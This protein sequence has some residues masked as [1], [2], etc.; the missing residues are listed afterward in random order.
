MRKKIW[1]CLIGLLLLGFITYSQWHVTYFY[2][3]V[4]AVYFLNEDTGYT[5][6]V[7]YNLSP[8]NNLRGQVW[9]TTDGG[10]S[11]DTCLKNTPYHNW[12]L[13]FVNDQ[14]GY[15]LG[16]NDSSGL[17]KTSNMGDSWDSIYVTTN[18]LFDI[19]FINK[20]T[21][22]VVGNGN[23][24]IYQT[25]DGGYTW[26]GGFKSSTDDYLLKICFSTADTGFALGYNQNSAGSIY[27]TTDKGFTWVDLGQFPYEF[28]DMHFFNGNEGI[29]VGYNKLDGSSVA[30]YTSNA[31]S[32]FTVQ[33]SL[34]LIYGFDFSS[35]NS[36]KGIVY[37]AT[38]AYGVLRAIHDGS[39]SKH[40]QWTKEATPESFREI[41]IQGNT[42]F[43]IGGT[44]SFYSQTN[45]ITDSVW[46]GD[47]N[48]DN[49]AN[50][51][52]ILSIGIAY[53][54]Q[55]I[56]RTGA[57][58][59]WVG[60]ACNDWNNSF[61]NNVNYKHAD[62]DGNGLIDSLDVSI[63]SSNYGLTH[64]K[65]FMLTSGSAADPDLYI[66]SSVDTTG[67]SMVFTAKIKLGTNLL[68]AA[69]VYGFAL[70]VNYNPNLIDSGSMSVSFQ[71]SWIASSPNFIS[72]V[73]DVY[74]SGQ[75][76][77]GFSRIDQVSV[78]GYGEVAELSCIITDNIDGKDYIYKTLALDFN[79]AKIIDN[80]ETDIA[81]NMFGDSVIIQQEQLS[82]EDISNESRISIYPSPFSNSFTIF[83][84]DNET[85]YDDII[86]FNTMGQEFNYKLTKVSG[87]TFLCN[88]NI[89]TGLYFLK[90]KTKDGIIIKKI[91]KL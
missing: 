72:L 22:Y 54:N 25:K 69:N 42:A 64:Y 39:A 29:V 91:K 44:G 23:A 14:I 56:V 10:I 12:S 75:I 18:K 67:A 47:A 38:G 13:H 9:R 83:L 80:L 85:I 40:L 71:N 28:K 53:G 5:A 74:G 52:D 68:P 51:N 3:Y 8:L 87:N 1:K 55:G 61:S 76:N 17:Y 41:D 36:G 63:V 43:A 70:S 57:T 59:S 88:P 84:P 60:Q 24:N 50:V 34:S 33:D 66:E 89:T 26:N 46:P 6:G 78:S 15:A 27:R 35:L 82:I 21:G 19:A 49:I 31:G 20:D 90:I 79:S 81:F 65:S 2:G 62:C 37:A 48:N 77:I 32:T 4:N 30:L 11:W 45:L 58:G 7:N 86:L 16:Y 73:K